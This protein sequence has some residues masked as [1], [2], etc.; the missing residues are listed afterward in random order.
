MST[1]S[2]KIIEIGE[3]RHYENADLDTRTCRNCLYWEFWTQE[4]HWCNHPKLEV[5]VDKE[6]TD[7][8]EDFAKREEAE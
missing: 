5:A 3:V 1:H 8:C 7:A 4:S 2:V 6:E